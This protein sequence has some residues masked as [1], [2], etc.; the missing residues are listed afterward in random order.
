[1][2]DCAEEANVD[3]T[4]KP[5]TSSGRKSGRGQQQPKSS[6]SA[7][8]PVKMDFVP[9]ALI[10]ARDF[11]DN[12]FPSK[13]VEVDA[14]GREVLVHFQNWSSRYDEWISMDSARL[15]PATNQ[16]EYTLGPPSYD[17]L[18]ILC[19]CPLQEGTAHEGLQI[20]GL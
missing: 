16:S 14:E 1:M 12:W 8:V 6:T 4:E 10:E 15:R 5:S 7:A 3:E 9:G 20:Q 11:A 19:L 2:A 13:I 18:L 17:R